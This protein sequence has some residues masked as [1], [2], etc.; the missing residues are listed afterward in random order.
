LTLPFVLIESDDRRV[1]QA[2]V[3]GRPVIYGDA[4]QVVVL[5]AAGLHAARAVLIT[6][7]AF[8]DVRNIVRAVRQVRPDLPI[9]ARADGVEAVRAL[10]TL[11]IQEVTSPE[12]EVLQRTCTRCASRRQR[13]PS[14]GL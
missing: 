6:V 14:R 13:D 11:G 10:Y 5:E 12:F 9:I 2:R 1:Q 7:P 3:A 8:P 4:S